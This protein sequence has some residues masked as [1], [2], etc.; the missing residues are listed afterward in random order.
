M[1]AAVFIVMNLIWT[2]SMYIMWQDAQRNSS[3]V[4]NHYN[5]TPLR[6]AFVVTEATKQVMGL[7]VKELICASDKNVTR[8]VYGTRTTKGTVVDYQIFA[9]QQDGMEM[10]YR[11]LEKDSDGKQDT[12]FF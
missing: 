6:A 11:A 9:Q 10:S 3:L 8:E 1:I 5:M 4:K 2:L 7:T 12:G